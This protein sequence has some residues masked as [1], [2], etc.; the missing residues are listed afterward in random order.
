MI[1]EERRQ[2][3]SASELDAVSIRDRGQPK[4]GAEQPRG[5]G[6]DGAEERS[7]SARM[8]GSA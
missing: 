6:G 3:R 4:L 7:T 5:R 1:D 8:R 2:A